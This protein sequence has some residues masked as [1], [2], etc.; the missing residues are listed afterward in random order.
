[1]SNDH[2]DP[3]R[4]DAPSPDVEDAVFS[5]VVGAKPEPPPARGAAPAPSGGL[6]RRA[7]RRLSQRLA[8]RS[9]V[10]PPDRDAGAPRGLRK[11]IVSGVGRRLKQ[12]ASRLPIDRSLDAVVD[13]LSDPRTVATVQ[14]W[15]TTLGSAGL[16]AAFQQ[17][18]AARLMFDFA[19]WCEGRIGRGHVMAVLMQDALAPTGALGQLTRTWGAAVGA[20]QDGRNPLEVLL[21]RPPTELLLEALDGAQRGM[22]TTLCALA[23]AA[24]DRPAPPP[25]A[26]LDVLADTF[27]ACDIPDVYKPLADFALGRRADLERR[28]EARPEG[29]PEDTLGEDADEVGGLPTLRR[30]AELRFV[31]IAYLVFV[32]TYL[33]RNLVD[34]LPTLMGRVRQE[35][36]R[37]REDQAARRDE[38]TGSVWDQEP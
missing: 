9:D 6:L 20:G 10:R 34:A 29:A 14:G 30:G 26:P 12:A 25:D 16:E 24:S 35:R 36:D 19:Q 37:A 11:R 15:M 2:D 5:E 13:M 38:E 17:E 28:P 18:P 33:V 8:R 23:C 1:M 4:D 32:E 7:G 3:A 22:L 31:L 27:Q 21:T